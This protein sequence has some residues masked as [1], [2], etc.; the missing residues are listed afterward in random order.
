MDDDNVHMID[1]S[2]LLKVAKNLRPIFFPPHPP[3]HAD[4]A[5]WI[6]NGWAYLKCWYRVIHYKM[7][8]LQVDW[9]QVVKKHTVWKSNVCKNAESTLRRQ[10][11]F[12]KRKPRFFAV[13]QLFQSKKIS[14]LLK[15]SEYV[16]ISIFDPIPIKTHAENRRNRPWSDEIRYARSFPF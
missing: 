10:R 16:S 14:N 1:D 11:R 12:D 5:V 3:V 7:Q 9:R 2:Y 8:F 13:L 15:D 6:L 4:S